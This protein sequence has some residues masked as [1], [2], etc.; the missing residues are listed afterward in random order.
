MGVDGSHAPGEWTLRTRGGEEGVG[1]GEGADCSS[2]AVVEGSSWSS[3]MVNAGCSSSTAGGVGC[4][5]MVV[6]ATSSSS[7]VEGADGTCSSVLTGG[8][9]WGCSSPCLSV[10]CPSTVESTCSSE[11]VWR[12]LSRSS[13]SA[14]AAMGGGMGEGE[15][16]ESATVVWNQSDS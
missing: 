4:L 5:S 11:A 13:E 7:V 8:S 3:A 2:R 15:R 16:A 1:M 6:R 14:G 12:D 9:S 10:G